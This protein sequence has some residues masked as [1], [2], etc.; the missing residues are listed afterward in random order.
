MTLNGSI[1][2]TFRIGVV[3]CGYWGE[4]HV[5]VLD[6]MP[7]VDRVVAIDGRPDVLDNIARNHPNVELKLDLASAIDSVDAVLI[8]T[9]PESHADLALEAIAAGKHVLVEKPMTRTLAEADE[10]IAAAKSAGV[11]LA[12]GH[13]FVHNAAVHKLVDLVQTGALGTIHHISAARLNLGLYRDDVNVIWD[14]AAHDIS[15][16]LALMGRLPDEVAAWGMRHTNEFAED[17]ASIRLRYREENVDSIIRVSWL[18]PLKVRQTTIV[19]SEKMAVYD[20]MAADERVKV[21]DRGRSPVRADDRG[22]HLA[23]RYGETRSP[24]IEFREPL[25]VQSQDFVEAC[26]TGSKPAADGFDG[27]AVVAVLEATDE[28][29]IHNGQPVPVST[30]VSYP[31]APIGIA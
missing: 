16:T 7:D 24:F 10:V 31:V 26:R 25:L 19:G 6:S 4:K 8:A 13:T 9:P 30:E 28:S 12:V 5:R 29:L 21:L 20:D 11:T 17:V 3:G 2:D 15:I 14:L 23:Y 18:D 1:A 22:S 27:R